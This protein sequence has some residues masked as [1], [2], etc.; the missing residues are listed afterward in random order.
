M[1][2]ESR[3]A[4][5]LPAVRT[6]VLISLIFIV[7]LLVWGNRWPWL[8]SIPFAIIVVATVR[9]ELERLRHDVQWEATTHAQAVEVTF[10]P[11]I[12][13]NR[14]RLSSFLEEDEW[15]TIVGSEMPQEIRNKVVSI[16][17]DSFRQASDEQLAAIA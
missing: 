15:T 6:I 14:A 12:I 10:V 17:Q 7:P 2:T 8:A 3:A 1:K 11:A 13:D 5:S 9:S 16:E 4:P